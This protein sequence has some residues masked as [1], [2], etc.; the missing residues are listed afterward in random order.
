MQKT[1]VEAHAATLA[2]EAAVKFLDLRGSDIIE[3]ALSDYIQQLFD[4]E[5]FEEF[6][7][8][9]QAY[10]V[11]T[12]RDWATQERKT[13]NDLDREKIKALLAE[14]DKEKVFDT[15]EMTGFFVEALRKR[16]FVINL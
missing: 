1:L 16:G 7:E 12:G 2:A 10:L 13:Q 3:K 15:E 9:K 11:M 4:F 6:A 5:E 14:I 8:A